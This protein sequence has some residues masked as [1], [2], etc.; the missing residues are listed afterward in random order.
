MQHTIPHTP[1]QN[2]VV[3]RNNLTLKEM[4]NRMI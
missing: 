1:Q 4:T 3:E 2:H